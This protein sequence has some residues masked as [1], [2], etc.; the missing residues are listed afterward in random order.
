VRR[1]DY[2]TIA[3]RYDDCEARHDNPPDAHLRARL[4]A[5]T[6]AFA[7]LDVA[8][9]T[10]NYLVAQRRAFASERVAWHGVDAS[11]EMLAVATGK[12]EGVSLLQGRAEALPFGDATFDYVSCNFALHHFDDKHAA[13]DEM[14]RVLKADGVLRI[15]NL[16]AE[17]SAG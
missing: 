5:T 12:L 6:G 11:A 2:A 3:P 8:C 4:E 9:G 16:A 15:A 13:L 7:L 10:G 17:H 14:R 1:T